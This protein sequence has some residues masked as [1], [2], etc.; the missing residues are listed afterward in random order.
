MTSAP[1]GLPRRGILGVAGLAGLSGVVGIGSVLNA[2]T[3]D[4]DEP[5][6]IDIGFCTDMSFHHEQALA[7]CQRVIGRP[8]GDPVQSLA[9]E[10][11]QNQSYERGLMHAWLQQWGESTRPPTSVMGWMG[12][13]IEAEQM[14]GLATSEQMSDLSAAQEMDK[15]AL[16]LELMRAH[17]VGGV[18]MAD[19]AVETASTEQVRGRATQMSVT[20]SYEISLMD[21]LLAGTYA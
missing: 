14:P 8:T 17:H 20:Q 7:M 3:P 18:Q 5:S 11:L 19:Y 2:A 16:F 9:A 13:S 21:S 6:E 12:M 1:A 4:S 15:G 10:I